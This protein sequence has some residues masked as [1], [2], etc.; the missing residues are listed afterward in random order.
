MKILIEVNPTMKTG[1]ELTNY[2]LK[3]IIVDCRED[4]KEAYYRL[5]EKPDA[6]KEAI[7]GVLNSK[8]AFTNVSQGMI[9]GGGNGP[10]EG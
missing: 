9:G 6:I 10:A 3:E 5:K 7:E 2:R 8:P 1:K 4:E